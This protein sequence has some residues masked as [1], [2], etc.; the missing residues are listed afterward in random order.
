MI[1]LLE[2]DSNLETVLDGDRQLPGM[3]LLI[4]L[5]KT[6]SEKSMQEIS[7]SIIQTVRTYPEKY[8]CEVLD[9]KYSER[10][11]LSRLE[12]AAVPLL[13]FGLNKL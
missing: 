2:M 4:Q 6:F 8:R 7:K 3:K 10:V 1:G 9:P 11:D 13:K 12:G 5:S